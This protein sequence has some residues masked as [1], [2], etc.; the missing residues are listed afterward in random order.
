MRV[1][2]FLQQYFPAVLRQA[3]KPASPERH[4]RQTEPD[5]VPELPLTQ[6][7]L[8]LIRHAPASVCPFFCCQFCSSICN[9]HQVL[10]SDLGSDNLPRNDDFDAAV[11]LTTLGCA[12]VGHGVVHTKS[13]G[14]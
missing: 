7:E 10:M 14:R 13:L 6:R 2:A 11:F 5:H 8:R 12:V 1:D 9:T 4:R 3:K